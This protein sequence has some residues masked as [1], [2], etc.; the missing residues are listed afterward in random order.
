MA[1]IHGDFGSVSKIY[2]E[3]RPRMPKEII[4]YIL[5]E[6]ES[7]EEMLDVGCGTGLVT[8]QFSDFVKNITATDNGREMLEV[9]KLE[10]KTKNIKYDLLP[11]EDLNFDQNKFDFVTAFS[12]FHWF[13]DS[14]SIG[15]IM[16]CL[17]N[18]GKFFVINRNMKGVFSE[19]QSECN[20]IF[21]KFLSDNIQNKKKEYKPDEILNEFGFKNIKKQIFYFSEEETRLGFF[22]F[23]K[24]TSIFS[25]VP[26]EFKEVAEKEVW[27]HISNR[28]EDSFQKEFEVV[29]VQGSK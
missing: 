21:R 15:N 26:N 14:V 11:T 3:F 1:N 2:N 22:N 9:A 8:K 17:K 5:S 29:V 28:I 25:I 23:L 24:T 19:L 10:N 6:S 12:S 27:I 4:D 13:T 18:N 16:R 20:Q 7:H